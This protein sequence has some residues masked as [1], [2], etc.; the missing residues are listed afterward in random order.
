MKVVIIEDEKLATQ[1]LKAMLL[2]AEADIEIIAE[3]DSVAAT[4]EWLQQNSA[5]ALIF[6]DI[7]LLDGKV[8]SA[9]EQTSPNCPVIFTTAYDD[10]LQQAFASNGIEYLLKPFDQQRL[11]AS[12]A[13]FH[14]L[15][16]QFSTVSTDL[17]NQ[18]QQALTPSTREYKQR[19]TIKRHDAMELVDAKELALFR[20]DHT[21]LF[22]YNGAGKYFPM[23]DFTLNA[24]EQQLSPK[25]F[26]RINRNEIINID[27]IEFIINHSKDKLKLKLKGLDFDC[28]TSS[29][30]TPEF[31]KWLDA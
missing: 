18:L 21:G 28:I 2:K 16:Q 26:F 3:L 20:L 27:F 7:E 9:F 23:H 13:K 29:H 30:R 22:A 1:K 31:R 12:L 5:P 11:E 4:L 6:S 8:F 24:L 17:V 25:M 15:G 19:F 14:R 10:Y